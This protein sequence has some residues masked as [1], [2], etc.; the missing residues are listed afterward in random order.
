ME[1]ACAESRP[2]NR[3]PLHGPRP[4]T[5]GFWLLAPLLGLLELLE[6]LELLPPPS[7]TFPAAL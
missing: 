7:S 3:A 1:L 2:R 6:L 5:P 4:L